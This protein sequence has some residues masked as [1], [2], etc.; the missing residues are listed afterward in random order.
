ML[1]KILKFYHPPLNQ[2]VTAS[3]DESDDN[4]VGLPTI[5]GIDMDKALLRVA[6]N[7]KL[8][9]L[10]VQKFVDGQENAASDIKQALALKDVA[11]AER[12]AHTVKGLAGNI[13]AAELQSVAADLEYE[14]KHLTSPELLTQLLQRFADTLNQVVS[15][16]RSALKS[17]PQNSKTA[18]KERNDQA[19]Q[20][21]LMQLKKLLTDNDS[22]AIDFFEAKRKN[23]KSLL[24]GS[25]L[26]TVYRYLSSYDYE[27]ALQ[28]IETI[29]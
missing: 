9:G 10:L 8:Y 29:Q 5:P 4:L 21:I 22:D 17:E 1:Q 25:Q 16:L 27:S 2:M 14:I 12:I 15:L 26:E 3:K 6:G 13:G 19:L 24:S 20:T 7:R 11:T 18:G 23:L 28:L